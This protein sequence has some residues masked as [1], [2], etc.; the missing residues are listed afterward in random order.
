[1]G[2]RNRCL[3]ARKRRH[4]LAGSPL[5]LHAE[6]SRQPRDARLPRLEQ[7]GAARDGGG[8]PRAGGGGEPAAALPPPGAEAM[9]ESLPV[10][11]GSRPL[12]GDRFTTKNH[13]FKTR[14][15]CPLA[16]PCYSARRPRRRGALHS[17]PSPPSVLSVAGVGEHGVCTDPYAVPQ[18][19]VSRPQRG[20][21]RLAQSPSN[22]QPRGHGARGGI[23]ARR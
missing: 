1:M 10:R 16:C 14:L 13:I 3:Q 6:A 12:G 21:V 20:P 11:T 17:L 15:H 2:G 22:L 23:T 8:G 7:C 4:S 9:Y 5:V 18:Q 19:A